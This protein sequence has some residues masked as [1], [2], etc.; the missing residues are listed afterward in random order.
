[1]GFF[2]F[3]SLALMDFFEGGDLDFLSEGGS[4]VLYIIFLNRKV[5]VYR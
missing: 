5:I 2:S 1:M 3:F 4:H